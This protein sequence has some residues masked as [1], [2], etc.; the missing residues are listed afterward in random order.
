MAIHLSLL[1]N[2]DVLFWEDAG[3]TDEVRLFRPSTGS[4]T[5]PALPGHD[6]FCAGHSYLADGK[7]F[8][9]GGHI[10]LNAAT[11]AWTVLPPM[12]FA[13]RQHDATLLPDGSVLV[14]GGTR[15]AGFNNAAGAVL[16]T[17]IWNPSNQSWSTLAPMQVNRVYHSTALLLPDGRVLSAGGGSPPATGD[18]DHRDAEIYSPP[19]LFKGRRPLVTTAP[20]VVNHGETFSV[21][22]PDAASIQ[23]VSLIRLPSAT[24]AFD[25]NQR[26]V[27]LSFTRVQ[28][29]LLV[30]SPANP[31]LCPPGHY[32]LF[33]VNDRGVPSVAK[34]IQVQTAPAFS[35]PEPGTVLPGAE[36]TFE[37]SPGT[38]VLEYWLYLG[39]ALG[40][41]DLFNSG[42]LGKNLS[43]R[44][45]GLPT[46]GRTIFARL[47]YRRTDGWKFVD[48]TYTAR[49]RPDPVMTSPPPGS[50]L[51]GFSTTFQW[52][53]GEQVGLYWLYVGNSPLTRDIFD[54]GPLT[55]TSVTATNLPADG[56]TLFVTLWFLRDGWLHREYTYKAAVL[57]DPEI[58]F[59]AG[60]TLSDTT[61]S[62]Q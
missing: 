47:W 38:E 61:V 45:T 53:A 11:P 35:R 56:R 8:I 5:T 40:S 57:R 43:V 25:Q 20:L 13:R 37:Y 60:S 50:T 31:N 17:E 46:D 6:I 48:A 27:G 30:V 41:A 23:K 49:P 9:T 12:A 58:I 42:S 52:T 15:S 54:S 44:V 51:T 39:N 16:E 10:D 7:L 18:H 21:E 19:Y 22:T 34:I 24:H 36:V 26:Y 1:P 2:S 32:M 28:G 59:P 3:Q 29:G 4:I 62:F 33:L 55:G 14:T